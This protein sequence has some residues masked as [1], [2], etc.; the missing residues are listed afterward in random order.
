MI[1]SFLLGLLISIL[2]WAVSWLPIWDLPIEFTN[3]IATVWGYMNAFSF[4]W[5]VGSM[6]LLFAVVSVYYGAMLAFDITL[7]IIHLFRG[8]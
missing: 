1:T 5:P 8:N 4:M 6:V 7:W 2:S 3:A